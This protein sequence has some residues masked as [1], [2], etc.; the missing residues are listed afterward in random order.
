[1]TD[2]TWQLGICGTFDVQNYGDL[3]FPPI[4]E[5]ELSRRLGRVTLQRFSYGARKPPDWPYEVRSLSELPAAAPGLDG[6]LIGG[7]HLIRFDKQVAPGYSP[8]TPAIHHPTGFW[9]SPALIAL[10]SGVPVVWNAPGVH[11]EIPR[12]A[13]PLMRL[14]IGRSDYVAVR[15]EPSRRALARFADVSPIA[16]VPDTA[17]GVSSLVDL[18]RPSPERI[19]IRDQDGLRDRYVLLQ[20]GAGLEPFLRLLRS[21]PD[22][23]R[24]HQLL[25]LP[26]G[27]VHGEDA[28]RFGRELPRAVRLLRW[29]R[30]LL[31]AELIGGAS[32]VVGASLHLAITALGFGVPVFRPAGVR[33]AK[34]AVLEE[35]ETV[36]EFPSR[37]ALDPQLFAERLGRVAPAPSARA[38]AT[39]LASH[40]DRVAEVLRARAGRPASE[41][42]VGEFW[43]SLPNELESAALRSS[44]FERPLASLRASISWGV[45]APLRLARRGLA[46]ARA[47]GG[48]K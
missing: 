12:W 1:M 34:H 16:C 45:T 24:G 21:H 44:R 2:R 42:R 32:A 5:R 22:L 15:D 38:A 25:V 19:R 7:G 43:Q 36:T 40:W 48:E 13:E 11:G 39:R 28:S 37:G 47:L 26:I 17:F 14:A 46:G 29:P 41:A 6:L 35:F 33:G 10:Q 31:L 27:P 20:A 9:L 8:L 4:A 23:V 30:P 3:L 18:E